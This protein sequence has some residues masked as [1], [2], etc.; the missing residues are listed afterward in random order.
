M[1]GLGQP[2]TCSHPYVA[3]NGCPVQSKHYTNYTKTLLATPP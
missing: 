1:A 3:Q 2:R